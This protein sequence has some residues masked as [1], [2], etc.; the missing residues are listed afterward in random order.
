M[1]VLASLLEPGQIFDSS[2]KANHSVTR[3]SVVAA[4]IATGLA[5][6]TG[7]GA[8]AQQPTQTQT[9]ARSAKPLR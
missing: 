5:V 2:T 4:A 9:Q 8:L 7:T 6:A 3:H 1:V